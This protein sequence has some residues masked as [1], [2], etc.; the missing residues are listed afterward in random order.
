MAVLANSPHCSQ[1]VQLAGKGRR[2]MV[3]RRVW[4]ELRGSS[5]GAPEGAGL[6]GTGALCVSAR[7]QASKGIRRGD[8]APQACRSQCQQ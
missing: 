3:L 6:R 8:K 7:A 4:K 1:S 2:G 5:P